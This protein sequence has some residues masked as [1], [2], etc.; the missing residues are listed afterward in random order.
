MPEVI[1]FERERLILDREITFFHF[2]RAKRLI[3]RALKEAY[4]QKEL[5]FF[6]YF[7][8]QRYI[9]K[10]DFPK[11][12]K[13]LELCLRFKG[14]DACSYNDKAICLAELGRYTEALD[15]FNQGLR[16]CPGQAFLYHNKGWLLNLLG[17][18]KEAVLC[19]KK[20]LEIEPYRPEALYSLADSYLAL[21]ENL[22]AKRYFK[23][24]LLQLKGKC[25]FMYRQTANR[26]K[27]IP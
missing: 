9:L 14:D 7:L 6:F 15:C 1:D 4:R 19:F 24:A 17:R 18:H 12:L 11:A 3:Q 25:S 22:L 26:L 10:E 23:K 8:A 21:G 5:F 20:A 16:L 13:Y 2:R 27:E